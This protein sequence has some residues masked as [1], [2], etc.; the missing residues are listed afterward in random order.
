MKKLMSFLLAFCMIIGMCPAIASANE[1][2]DSVSA[3]RTVY[4]NSASEWSTAQQGEGGGESVLIAYNGSDNWNAAGSFTDVNGEVVEQ[5]VT[6]GVGFNTSRNALVS[7]KIPENFD[8]D[9]TALVTLTLTLKYFKQASVGVRLAVYGNSVDGTWSASSAN[10]ATFGANGSDSGLNNLE[11]LGLTSP[12]KTGSAGEKLTLTSYALTDYVKQMA[13]EGKSEV[14]FRLA[15]P[16]GGAWIYNAETSNAPVLKFEKGFAT[17]VNV[18]TVF[19]DGKNETD[20]EYETISKVIAGSV[21]TYS[22]TPENTKTVGNDIYVY[23]EEKSTLSVT[24]EEDGSSEIVI[25]YEKYTADNTFNGYVIDDEGAWCWFA[26]PRAISYKNDEGTIDLTLIG[27]I[28]VHGNIK[29]TQINNLTN[30]VDEVLV[31]T[32]LQPDDHNN[33]TFLVLPDERIVV[34]YSRHTDEACFW[35]RVTKEKGDITTFGEEKCLETS[36][37]TTYP[38]PF[39]MSDDPDHIYLCWRGIGW[40]PTIAKL[41]IPNENGD[42]QFTYGP[43]QMVQST[44]AR[45]YAKYASNGKDKIYVS[46]TTGH[47]DNE[48]PNWLYFNQI[49]INTMTMQDINGKVMSTIASGPLNVNKTN[50]SQTNIVDRTSGVR[51]WLWQVAVADDGYPVIANVRING[52]KSVHDYYYV[53]WN[54]TE[55]VK[56]FVTNGGGKFHPSNTEYCYSGGMSIDTDNPNVMYVS[57][58][59]DGVFGS[60][61]EIVKYTMSDDGTEVLSEEQITKNSIKNNVR[62][63][64]VPNSGDNDVKLLWMSGDYAYWMVNKNYPAGYPTAAMSSTPLPEE[65]VDIT[66]AVAKEDYG[67][68]GGAFVSTMNTANIVNA[69]VGDEFTVSVDAYL[70]GDYTGT[71]FKMGD[72]SVS[73]KNLTTRYSDNDEANFP[74]LVLTVNGVDY[75]STNVYGTSD[76][77]K[78]YSTGTS[79]D[80]YFT[81]YDKYVNLTVVNDG[82][83]ITLYRDGLVDVKEKISANGFE[84]VK[85]G[86]FDGYVENVS[87]FDRALNHDEIKSLTENDYVVKDPEVYGSESVKIVSK[88]SSGEVI[89]EE[90]VEL[91]PGTDVYEFVPENGII[92]DGIYYSMYGYSFNETDM[93]AEVIYEKY[94]KNGENLVVDG[95]FED[96]NG[97]FS[98]GT[99][100]SPERQSYFKD[101]CSDWF[102]IVNRDTDASV[103]YTNTLKAD[104]YALGTRWNDGVLGLCSMANFI[105]VEAGKTY[106]VSYDY[107]HKVNGTSA[108]YISTSFVS[109]KNMS[110]GEQSGCNIPKSVTTDWQTNEFVITAPEDG[111]IYFHFSCLGSGNAPGGS[112]NGSGPYWFFDNFEVY[113][114]EK[115]FINVT[116]EGS[117]DN[118]TVVKVENISINDVEDVMVYVVEYNAENEVVKVESKKI[119]VEANNYKMP[120]FAVGGN[121]KVFV[122][123]ENMLP[124]HNVVKK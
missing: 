38:S 29:A 52:G 99:W 53:K 30:K 120:K 46:Y 71:I 59:V 124:L 22:D 95:T 2:V 110:A 8:A 11:L 28:D 5:T 96:E 121:I 122:W 51:N 68:I 39:L 123:N 69:T 62:P 106:F 76:D 113:E 67:M 84:N 102:Y 79:G 92:K 88:T 48:D 26:D 58:P 7:F 112:N 60:V 27:Y 81:E 104:D 37:N 21:Y 17:S 89:K 114:I 1:N 49:D 54:G 93:E 16:C 115:E 78:Y 87:V 111:Y 82:E 9:D 103:L 33:P 43:Y 40:H 50:T 101:D 24:V 74:R 98:W 13:D 10:K 3:T 55:W 15:I 36:A 108:N 70:S 35:Y 109:E 75:A 117:T 65:K 4:F 94:K 14:T 19:Y 119:D 64:A 116:I 20:A 97:N 42:M 100:Q 73:V 31:R 105:P 118:E 56:T 61:F 34:F 45:P 12:I 63:W 44:G 86:G 91:R 107:K 83:Y 47:P 90:T 66:D 25:V 77:W 18:K 41:S 6:S 72:V 32:N 57:K 80:Y 85:V 23:S